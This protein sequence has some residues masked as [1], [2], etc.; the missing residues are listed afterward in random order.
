M[1]IAVKKVWWCKKNRDDLLSTLKSVGPLVDKVDR[2]SDRGNATC[3]AW[4]KDLQDLVEAKQIADDCNQKISW[5]TFKLVKRSWLSSSLMDINRRI[6]EKLPEANMLI[7]NIVQTL[8]EIMTCPSKRVEK[9]AGLVARPVPSRI[10]GFG[11]GVLQK[12]KA[13][14]ESEFDG[15]REPLTIGLKG[16]GEWEDVACKDG[17]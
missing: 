4:L 11:N 14:V 2:S 3:Q 17:A 16:T 7:L 5:R 10:V 12:L 1:V 9:S 15:S 6:K 8:Q 13:L